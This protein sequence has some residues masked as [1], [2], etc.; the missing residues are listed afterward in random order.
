[1][2][3]SPQEIHVRM[4]KMHRIDFSMVAQQLSVWYFKSYLYK[5][6]AMDKKYGTTTA[7]LPSKLPK[8]SNWLAVKT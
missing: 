7:Y 5:V 8:G 1:M 3:D 6:T 2:K 4:T